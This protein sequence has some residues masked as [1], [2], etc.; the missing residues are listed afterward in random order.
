MSASDAP[1]ILFSVFESSGD[2]LAAPLIH[3]LRQH[4]PDTKV[5]ALGG[6]LMQTAGAE[7]LEDSAEQ[8]VIGFNVLA[9]F[10]EHRRR[11][12]ELRKWLEANRID[13]F[14]PVDSPAANWSVCNLV[15]KLQ[16][17]ARIVHVVL[18]QIWAWARWRIRKLRRLTD[19]VIC[20]LPFEP[21]WLEQRGVAGTFVGHPIFDALRD[22]PPP[23]HGWE[24]APQGQTRI[25]VLPGSR[26]SEIER[27]WPTLLDATHL[28]QQRLPD[29][30]FASAAVH[31]RA[32]EQ[33]R[34]VAAASGR[35][36]VFE[37]MAL[38]TDATDAVLAWS[39]H[40]L[41]ASGTVTLQITAHRKPMVVM[42]RLSW[43]TL[44]IGSMVMHTRVFSLPNVLEVMAG[45]DEVVPEFIPHRGS[46]QPLADAVEQQV[47]DAAA[48][49]AMVERLD[50][51]A[52]QFESHRYAEEA[53]QTLLAR[54]LGR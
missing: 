35:L 15:R 42:Y 22:Q 5:F 12:A 24:G 34:E 48:T 13:L 17:H 54:G 20:I 23:T 10:Q 29:A 16:P 26:R 19:H 33:M 7:L 41:A 49:A 51:I 4:V 53:T 3:R 36:D 38:Q 6:P 39:T 27:N 50:A 21:Q 43:M 44:L 31:P 28:L 30:V 32:A 40:V 9:K 14:V 2:R 45:R 11:L 18:P 52:T 25:A 47:R 8:S 1:T 37:P 46:A